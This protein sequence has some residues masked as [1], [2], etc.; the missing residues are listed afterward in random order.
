MS[1]LLLKWIHILSATVLFGTGVGSA[2]YMFAANRSR[3][4]AAIR[5]ATKYV[6]IADW[7]FTT[8]A[9]VIQLA[10]GLAMAHIAGYPLTDT[11]LLWSLALYGFAGACWLPVVWMQIRMRDMAGAALAS[12]TP[13]PERYW[14][15]DRWWIALGSLAFPAVVVVFWLMVVKPA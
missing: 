4:V 12:G 13:L 9:V 10:T 7:M 6:V 3:D 8:P 1:Y 11:W 14:R 15:F 2:F 5:F